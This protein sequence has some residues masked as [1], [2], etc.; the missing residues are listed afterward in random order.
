MRADEGT[1]TRSERRVNSRV[2]VALEWNESGQTLRIEGRTTD[3]SPSGCFVI[4]AQ[5]A[6]VGQKIRLTNLVNGQECE[7][8]IVR[9]GQQTPAGWE[10]G[11]RLQ[12]PSLEFWGFDF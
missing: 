5:R 1:H 7:A 12:S 8:Q 6:V 4:A 2:P 3:I 11:I 10:L 9:Q